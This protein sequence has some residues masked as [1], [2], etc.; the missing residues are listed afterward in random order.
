MSRSYRRSPVNKDRTNTKKRRFKLK[1]FA[2]RAVRRSEIRGRKGAYRRYYCSR[3]ISDY[4]ILG[5]RDEKELRRRDNGDS[6]LRRYFN[7]AIR[8]K[9][10]SQNP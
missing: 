3:I 1:T 4:C 8:L 5:E 6:Y 9:I 2:G 7:I 10:Q